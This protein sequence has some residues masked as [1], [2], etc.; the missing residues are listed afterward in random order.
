MKPKK[1]KGKTLMEIFAE[2][3]ITQE[4]L[5]QEKKRQE[6]EKKKPQLRKA[7]RKELQG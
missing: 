3:N 1:I 2:E 7:T 4:M 6:E 5:D